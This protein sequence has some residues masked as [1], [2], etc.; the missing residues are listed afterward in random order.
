MYYTKNS[1]T[2]IANFGYR[3]MNLLD[4]FD[5]NPKKSVTNKSCLNTE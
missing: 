5:P 1:K 4:E 2:S 3:I